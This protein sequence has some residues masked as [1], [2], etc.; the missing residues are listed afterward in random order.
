[1]PNLAQEGRRQAGVRIRAK[2]IEEA[3]KAAPGELLG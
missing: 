2:A 3:G 1:M